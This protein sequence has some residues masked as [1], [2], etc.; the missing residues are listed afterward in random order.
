MMSSFTFGVQDLSPY[1]TL[2]PWAA[3]D[4]EPVFTD[5]IRVASGT[6]TRNT[7]SKAGREFFRE[8][9]AMKACWV[10]SLSFLPLLGSPEGPLQG[11]HDHICGLH[12]Y[13]GQMHR[14]VNAHHFCAHPTPELR[15]CVLY[16][17][18]RKD[19]KLIG[20]E[21]I[22][23]ARLF[24]TLPPEEKKLWHSH[25]YEVKAG[26]LAAPGLPDSVEKKLMKDL[27][28][29]YGKTWHT[30]QVDR[31]DAL[32]MGIPQLMM[33][34]TADGQVKRESR[35]D[36]DRRRKRS[37]LPDPYVDPEA[38]AWRKGAPLQLELK[39]RGPEINRIPMH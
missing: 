5:P 15:Q 1:F 17:S 2:E 13:S 18:N 29:T 27:A 32:P 7:A 19:A 25:A 28:T 34:F 20:I 38:D 39:S 16:D 22:I 10:L 3:I 37:D 23:S 33:S 24:K 8:D 6:R 36:R 9:A 12:F 11:I 21:Y 35:E 26:L 30:W 4:P 31:G 14:Q